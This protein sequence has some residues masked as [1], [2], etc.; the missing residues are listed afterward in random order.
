[1]K[2]CENIEAS[3]LLTYTDIIVFSCT[4]ILI[5]SLTTFVKLK[6]NWAPKNKTLHYFLM[7]RKLTL[8]LFVTSLVS[9]WYGGIFGVTRIAFEQGIYNFITQGI[10]WH[11]TYLIFAFFIV[12]KIFK[13]PQATSLA[14]LV[15]QMFGSKAGKICALFNLLDVIPIV[16]ITSLGFFLSTLF[17]E[18]PHFCMAISTIFIAFYSSFGGFKAIVLSDFFQF[19]SMLIAIFSVLI[20]SIFKIGSPINLV[21]TLPVTHW[22]PLGGESFGNLLIW[23]FIALT[24]LVD[25]NFY[26]RCLACPSASFAKKGILYSIIIWF[27]IDCCTTISG[28]YA[29]ASIPNASPEKAY[30]LFS[31]QILP[32]GLRGLFCAGI[33]SMIVSTTDSYLFTA[34]QTLSKDL[35]DFKSLIAHKISI[36]LIGIIG[37]LIAILFNGNIKYIWE[38]FGSLS[39]ACLFV[40]ICLGFFKQVT[41]STRRFAISCVTSVVVLSICEFYLDSIFTFHI[42]S[43][44]LGSLTSLIICLFPSILK[45]QKSYRLNIFSKST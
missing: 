24:T 31:L 39:T 44:Y 36:L 19:F 35:L 38:F 27:S 43:F 5:L 12:D 4:T 45:N 8:P 6:F 33:V 11:G 3:S 10:F 23:G 22:D 42:H 13:Y 26:Q 28:F 1:M 41:I 32:E 20:F 25:P 7:E 29:K 21:E 15:E 17:E 2:F 18:D 16:Y 37:V 40:P 9:T 34:G 30:L 14:H